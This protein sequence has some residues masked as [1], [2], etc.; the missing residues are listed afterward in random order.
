MRST[1]ISFV[2]LVAIIFSA[3]VASAS[4]SSGTIDV[5]SYKALVCHDVTCASLTPGIINLRPTG[6]T[7]VTIDDINGV[8]GIAWGNELGW[9]TFDTAGPEAVGINTA[10]GALSGRAWAQA[11]SWINFAPTGQGVSIN[12]VGEFVGW[13]WVGGPN[14]GW[15]KFD[16]AFAGACVKTDWRPTSARNTASASGGGSSG[17]GGPVSGVSIDLC[18]NLSGTQGSIPSGYGLSQGNCVPVAVDMCTNVP[19]FQTTLPVGYSLEVNG[20][21]VLSVDYCPNISGMQTVIPAD[22]IVAPSGNC[23]SSTVDSATGALMPN[24]TIVFPGLSQPGTPGIPPVNVSQP[25]IAAIGTDTCRNLTGVQSKVPEGYIIDYVGDCVLPGVDYC[26]NV[27][28]RQDKVPEGFIITQDGKCVIDA[29]LLVQTDI[30]ISEAEREALRG[31]ERVIAY[32]F[33]PKKWLVPVRAPRI[34][35]HIATVT[36]NSSFV[37]PKL[38]VVSTALTALAGIVLVSYL[39]LLLFVKRTLGGL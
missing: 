5:T 22:L 36:E 3:H 29:E 23:V 30:S 21:C 12:S 17:G 37:L 38:D 19:G 14:G 2:A 31:T 4:V 16:C 7:P 34:T 18:P 39:Y 26:P 32:P 25:S 35:K 13:A 15:I 9:I 6:T 8:D 24:E 10:T 33:I 28:G 27:L 11:G 1:Q 20:L